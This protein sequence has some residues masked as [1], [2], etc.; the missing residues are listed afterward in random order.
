M[1]QSQFS[2][3]LDIV[4]FQTQQRTFNLMN[5]I[6]ERFPGCVLKDSH[7]GL[8]LYQISSTNTTLAQVKCLCLSFVFICQL[9]YRYTS[10]F[11]FICQFISRCLPIF[12]FRCLV[13]VLF[14]RPF[15]YK[16][17]SIYFSFIFSIHRYFLFIFVRS[18]G[19]NLSF[20]FMCAFTFL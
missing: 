14:I 20:L 18:I 19:V 15:V 12:L 17:L 10:I 7:P 5:F 2:I 4:I 6:E 11:L 1:F 16:C 13:Y 3:R 9:L 8:V